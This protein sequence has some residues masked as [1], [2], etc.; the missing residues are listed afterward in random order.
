M[1]DLRHCYALLGL[2][3]GASPEEVRRAFRA[4]VSLWHP[5]RFAGDPRLQ[6]EAQERLRLVIEAYR[7]IAADAASP[8]GTEPPPPGGRG[9]V[10]VLR[11]IGAFLGMVPNLLFA[12]FS[13][14]YV[15]L[16]IGRFGLTLGAAAYVLE[17]ALVPLLFSAAWNLAGR[18][19]GLVR[20]LYVGFTLFAALV[21]VVDGSM[22]RYG[23]GEGDGAGSSAATYEGF[24]A[25]VAT[26]EEGSPSGISPQLYPHGVEQALPA[27]RVPLAPAAPEAPLAPLAPAAPV[28]PQARR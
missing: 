28:V 12:F 22:S 20:G 24:G 26:P 3:P 5:D 25:D 18:G 16:A 17:L 11:R 27:P 21:A 23:R 10:A 9:G 6:G 1:N 2:E 14:T 13:F 19:G 7:R 4:R 8:E 15:L